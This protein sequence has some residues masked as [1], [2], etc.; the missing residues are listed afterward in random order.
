MPMYSFV[1]SKCYYPAE[2]IR[3]MSE[4]DKAVV[5]PLC[6]YQMRRDYSADLFH[7]ASDRYD[8]PIISD[9]MAVSMDQIEEHKQAFPDVRIT[10][11]G[12]PIMESYSQHEDYLK[13]TGQIKHPGKTR[14][15]SRVISNK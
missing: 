12:Q 11:E 9:A 7:T 4:S 8:N 5:C 13:K 14:V 10:D 3:P 1:C 6:S 15:K 2:V